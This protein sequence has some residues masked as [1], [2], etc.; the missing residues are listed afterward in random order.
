MNTNSRYADH[1]SL[2]TQRSGSSG[3]DKHKRRQAPALIDNKWFRR[4][5]F[6]RKHRS[7]AIALI[8]QVT[9]AFTLVRRGLRTEGGGV[10][11]ESLASY[12]DMPGRPGVT[13]S[14]EHV[15]MDPLCR[16]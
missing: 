10:S 1:G 14:P 13:V 5:A 3:R 12:L 16:L 7:N 4:L 11:S 9:A 15:T 2:E 6:I 8:M